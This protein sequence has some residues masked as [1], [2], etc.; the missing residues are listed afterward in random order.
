MG[1]EVTLDGPREFTVHAEGTPSWPGWTCVR[2]GEVVLATRARTSTCPPAGWRCRCGWSGGADRTTLGRQLGVTGGEVVQTPYWSPEVVSAS[3]RR[4]VG[5][6]TKSFG[7]PYGS[8]RG[9]VELTVVVLPRRPCPSWSASRS[10]RSRS[11][12]WLGCRR[13]TS[14]CRTDT[15]GCSPGSAG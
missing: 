8:Q 14:R 10:S 13:T 6:T 3:P 12:S 1:E 5:G 4:C 11:A 15:C 9:G 2:D 7:E